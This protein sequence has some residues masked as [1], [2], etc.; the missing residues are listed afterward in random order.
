MITVLLASATAQ[1]DLSWATH[2]DPAIRE[3]GLRDVKRR[4]TELDTKLVIKLLRDKDWGVQLEAIR[5]FETNENDDVRREL[6]DLTMRGPLLRTRR[7]AAQALGTT[8][9]AGAA[10]AVLARLNRAG[11]VAGVRAMDEYLRDM[12]G[13]SISCVNHSSSISMDSSGR[14]ISLAELRCSFA[15]FINY[16]T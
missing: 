4:G 6:V 1:E 9:R 2:P 8:D 3:L 5:T 12:N 14:T 15:C 10:K 7:T 11:K 13:C 16:C